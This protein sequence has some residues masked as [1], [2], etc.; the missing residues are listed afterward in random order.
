MSFIIKFVNVKLF[1]SR[2]YL[3]FSLM[4]FSLIICFNILDETKISLGKINSNFA[5]VGM[6]FS[7]KK[8][9][10]I[11][12]NVLIVEFKYLLLKVKISFGIE[13]SI[14]IESVSK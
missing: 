11:W 1:P 7:V 2:K 13:H 10:C 3:T 6:K 8:I 14:S 4:L 5:F 9:I 12:V